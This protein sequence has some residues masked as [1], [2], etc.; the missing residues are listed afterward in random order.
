MEGTKMDA[1]RP[2][3]ISALDEAAKMASTMGC[4][5]SVMVHFDMAARGY[6]KGDA[7]LA[8][9]AFLQGVRGMK[10]HAGGLV[11]K[12]EAAALATA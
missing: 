12:A 2:E 1:I 3:E 6:D 7:L 5:K 9:S 11:S 10:D 8:R 4:P